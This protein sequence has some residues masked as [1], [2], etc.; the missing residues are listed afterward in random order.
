MDITACKDQTYFQT[1]AFYKEVKTRIQQD[2]NKGKTLYIAT[3][4]L[5]RFN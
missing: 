1:E 3:L 5:D 2:E 4:D